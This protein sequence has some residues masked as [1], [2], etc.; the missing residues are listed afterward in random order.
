MEK[1]LFNIKSIEQPVQAATKGEGLPGVTGAEEIVIYDECGD[2]KWDKVLAKEARV[3]T[4]Q[5][6]PA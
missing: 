2:T 4:L 5:Q 3:N 6:L 1:N